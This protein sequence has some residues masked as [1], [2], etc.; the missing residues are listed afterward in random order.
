MEK[1]LGMID[2]FW[3]FAALETDFSLALS[4]PF[5]MPLRTMAS[6]FSMTSTT[7]VAVLPILWHQSLASRVRLPVG[8]PVFGSMST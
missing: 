1:S 8:S 5:W 4:I 3:I 7:V 6:F 2:H